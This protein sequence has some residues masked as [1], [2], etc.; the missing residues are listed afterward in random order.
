R[1]RSMASRARCSAASVTPAS[2]PLHHLRY[3][4]PYRRN[5]GRMP[6]MD[7]ILYEV[8]ERVA[9]ITLNRPDRRNAQNPQLLRELD[10]PWDIA[11]ADGD[12]Q[13]IRLNANHPHLSH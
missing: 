13:V 6:E 12:V 7:F 5:G 8:V 9:V 3:R 11:A 10:R 4:G 1:M 2:P